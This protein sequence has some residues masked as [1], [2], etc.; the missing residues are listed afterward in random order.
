MVIAFLFV[1]MCWMA[2]CVVV[3]FFKPLP[4]RVP[5]YHKRRTKG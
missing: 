5:P 1:G 3:L 4:P 2:L